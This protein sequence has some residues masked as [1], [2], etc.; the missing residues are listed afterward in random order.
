MQYPPMGYEPQTMTVRN[1]QTA[2]SL[3]A[4]EIDA[5]TTWLACGWGLGG[6]QAYGPALIGAP[7][8]GTSGV[9]FEISVNVPEWT[10][11]VHMGFLCSGLGT[12]TCEVS[13]DTYNAVL[14]IAIAGTGTSGTHS[15]DNA[16]MVWLAEPIG[17]PGVNGLNRALDIT[18]QDSSNRRTFK[19][20]ITDADT[21]AGITLEVYSVVILP[22]WPDE[23]AALP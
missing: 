6:C 8:V 5:Y 4:I 14:D 17:S 21:G 23:S 20:T 10:Q 13:G 22:R 9:E 12:I 3:H 18:Y 11:H 16:Q 19:F 15:I 7:F 1:G 2:A